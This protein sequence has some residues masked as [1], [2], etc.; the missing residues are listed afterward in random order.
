MPGLPENVF[1][2]TLVKPWE[3]TP[4]VIK[5]VPAIL[6]DTG[7]AVDNDQSGYVLYIT[8]PASN[9]IGQ[10]QTL[11]KPVRYEIP[12]NGTVRL[13]LAPSST[14]QPVGR[15]NVKY[16]KK[17][18]KTPIHE[19]NWVVPSRLRLRTFSFIFHGDPFDLPLDIYEVTQISPAAE[20]LSDYNTLQWLAAP[21]LDGDRV[22]LT[23][24]P[25]ITL[26][27]LRQYELPYER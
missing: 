10:M 13:Q 1:F 23:Y 21:P 22:E 8:P 14:F 3:Y 25:G 16:F 11:S 20:W 27:I 2:Q 6:T 12:N 17:P 15:Y 26:D 24:Q 7:S 9:R 4:L 19:E 5:F 18:Q